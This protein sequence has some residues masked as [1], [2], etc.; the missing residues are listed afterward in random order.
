L[1]TDSF[2]SF[3]YEF[4]TLINENGD[5]LSASQLADAVKSLGEAVSEL[6]ERLSALEKS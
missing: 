5:A 6:H 1:T 2:E 3:T 4:Q